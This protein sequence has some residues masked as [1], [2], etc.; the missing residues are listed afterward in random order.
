MTTTRVVCAVDGSSHSER[1]LT[2][3]LEEAEARGVPL[4]VVIARPT[5]SARWSGDVRLAEPVSLTE[6]ENLQKNAQHLLA[7]VVRQRGRTAGVATAVE[8]LNG[9]PAEVIEDYLQPTDLLV[10]GSRGVGG[11]RRLLLGSVSSAL[12]QTARCPVLVVRS[13]PATEPSTRSTPGPGARQSS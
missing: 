13:E 2:F 1:A 9:P 11:V 12:V 10:I 3:A 8:V 6:A 5:L 4:T 7:D